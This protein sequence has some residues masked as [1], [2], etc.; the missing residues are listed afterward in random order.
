MRIYS[1]ILFVTLILVS[2]CNSKIEESDLALIN[3]YWRIDFITQK[4]ETF[5]PKGLSKLIDHYSLEKGKGLRKKVQPLIDNKFFV[6]NDQNPFTVVYE[7]SDCYVQ[8]ETQWDQ[9][10]EKILKLNEEE[11]VLEH[12]EKK[13]HYVKF[14]NALD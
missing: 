4:N 2:G 11:L 3:G 6:T 1:W 5:R 7:G 8:F 12:S 10:R 13:Y 14:D 9:W